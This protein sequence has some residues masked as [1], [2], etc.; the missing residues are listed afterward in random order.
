[1]N[2]G[3][4]FKDMEPGTIATIAGAPYRVGVPA[5]EAHV[6]WPIGVARRPNGDMIV[7][8]W[9]CNRMWRIDQEG[10]LHIFAGDGIPG[11]RGNGGPA[12]DARFSGPHSLVL[13]KD[14]NMYVAD[15]R[16]EAVHKIKH[17]A[18]KDAK[19]LITFVEYLMRFAYELPATVIRRTTPAVSGEGAGP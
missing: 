9:H 13:D 10:T 18:R 12:I 2:L 19:S 16:N 5:N 3:E 14:S 8:D 17:M 15:L 7:V 4:F 6:G 11:D 1:M